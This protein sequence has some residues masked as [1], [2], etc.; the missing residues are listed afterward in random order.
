LPWGAVLSPVHEFL[1]RFLSGLQN[2]RKRFCAKDEK[3]LQKCQIP[4]IF[5]YR[6]A[7]L[8]R[9]G[10][11]HGLFFRHIP[12]MNLDL[13]ESFGILKEVKTFFEEIF[14]DKPG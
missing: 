13:S 11:S 10:F 4:A 3:P 6:F 9:Y 14:P 1:L 12:Q 5:Y 8:A 2:F 7:L